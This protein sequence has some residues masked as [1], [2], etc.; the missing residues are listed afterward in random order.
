MVS[1]AY[2]ALTGRSHGEHIMQSVDRMGSMVSTACK[3]LAGWAHG[4][5]SM[6]RA[7]RMGSW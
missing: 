5:H 6:Q 2:K 7:D 4:E 1:T 3:V